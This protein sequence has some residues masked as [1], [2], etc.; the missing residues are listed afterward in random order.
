VSHRSRHNASVQF[1]TQ[2]AF[3]LFDAEWL[4]L[5]LRATNAQQRATVRREEGISKKVDALQ[6]AAVRRYDVLEK[7]RHDVEAQGER[8]SMT[9]R[10]RL[11]SAT[12]RRTNFLAAKVAAIVEKRNFLR[13][14]QHS[15]SLQTRRMRLFLLNDKIEQASRRRWAFLERRRNVLATRNWYAKVLA[16][17]HVEARAEMAAF[18]LETWKAKLTDAA[19]RRKSESLPL[20][21]QLVAL[22]HTRVEHVLRSH[23]QLVARVV[24]R[25]AALAAIRLAELAHERAKNVHRKWL[26]VQQVKERREHDIVFRRQ[27]V[28]SESFARLRYVKL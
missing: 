22:R 9:L 2:C 15:T 4:N 28:A 3:R 7:R 20:F 25:K 14:H 26:H 21:A 27:C 8:I 16:H 13:A 5:A 18:T 12:T 19:T 17:R 11:D 6:A 10:L 23:A 1:R 24:S